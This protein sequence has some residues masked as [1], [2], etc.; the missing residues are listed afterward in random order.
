[1]F[2]RTLRDR[3]RHHTID[4]KRRESQGKSGERSDQPH[5]EAA[6]R[7]GIV[8]HLFH[9]FDIV[10]GT[11]LSTFAAAARIELSNPA[12]LPARTAMLMLPSSNGRNDAGICVY[13]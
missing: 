9:A 3:I 6:Q 13:G 12:V 5:I 4:A 8:N 10:K 2:A 11:D 7:T 1:D